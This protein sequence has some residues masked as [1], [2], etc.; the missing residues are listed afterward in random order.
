MP[1]YIENGDKRLKGNIDFNNFDIENL[2]AIMFKDGQE[3]SDIIASDLKKAATE[4]TIATGAV[5]K[6]AMVHTIDGEG[7]A[8]DDLA[9]INGGTAGDFLLIYPANAARN[10][11]IKHGTGNIVTGDGADYLIP[12]DGMV[13]MHYDGSNW[14]MLPAGTSGGSGGTASDSDI[15]I[16]TKSYT[17]RI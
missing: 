8:D 9:T 5:T 12:D 15:I 4:L 16:I 2:K 6:T 1:E 3:F 11:T 7:D 10:I 17:S 13:W 14:R